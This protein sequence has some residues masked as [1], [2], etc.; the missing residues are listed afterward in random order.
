M[1]RKAPKEAVVYDGSTPLTDSKQEFFCVLYT[2]NTTPRF[3]GHGQNSYAFAY[4]HQDRIDKL[5]VELPIT[6]TTKGRGKKAKAYS[7]YNKALSD[8]KRIE[9][10]CRSNSYRLLIKDDIKA[11][12]NFLMDELA[13]YTIID[14]ELLY[15][16]EQR[17]DLQ[18]K[19]QAIKHHD[20]RESRIREKI[21]IKHDFK[22]I[23]GIEYVIP[24]GPVAPLKK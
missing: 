17:H 3:F 7:A 15:V 5:Q 19:V 6:S 12:C 20:Q 11:R 9:A 4:G 23:D 2:S 24:T 16:I 14:R 13:A 22:P 21:D 1:A 10:T 18:S 8:I